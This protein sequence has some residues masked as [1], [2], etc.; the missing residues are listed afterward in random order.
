M[1]STDSLE[2][3]AAR[4]I[5]GGEYEDDDTIELELNEAAV[6]ALTEASLLAQAESSEQR[7]EPGLTPD[8]SKWEISAVER[9]AVADETAARADE[10]FEQEVPADERGLQHKVIV[11]ARADEGFGPEAPAPGPKPASI[12]RAPARETRR[13]A[14]GLGMVAAAAVLLGGVAYLATAPAG[15]RH[16]TAPVPIVDNNGSAPAIVTEAPV[17]MSSPAEPTSAQLPY[18]APVP[19]A[20][21][22]PDDDSPVRYKN[23]F[24][25]AEVFEFPAGITAVQARDAVAELLLQRALERKTLLVKKP[26]RNVNTADQRASVT[27][28]RVT[29]RS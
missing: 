19:P 15:A 10:G 16:P 21:P 29:P 12:A 3:P 25:A 22:D 14:L 6:R 28:S 26:Q 11:A 24:D 4:V 20:I 8:G 13:F 9:A 1:I 7:A 27:A 2:R 17:P 23:P 18:S 5:R